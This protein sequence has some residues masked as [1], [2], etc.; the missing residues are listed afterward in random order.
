MFRFAR[1]SVKQHSYCCKC[2]MWE[3]SGIPYR[4]PLVDLFCCCYPFSGVTT[5]IYIYIYAS[6]GVL[7]QVL[8]IAVGCR[9]LRVSY[10]LCSSF[11]RRWR[12]LWS[13][14]SCCSVYCCTG[15][16]RRD[17]YDCVRGEEEKNARQVREDEKRPKKKY[18]KKS[19][20]VTHLRVQKLIPGVS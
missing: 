17:V 7:S 13:C 18:I 12:S 16:R 14:T 2:C 20:T 11:C 15:L 5:R 9:S 1:R 4:C 19:P 3:C 6:A 8:N 10:L